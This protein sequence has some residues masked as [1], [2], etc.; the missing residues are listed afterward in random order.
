MGALLLS[1]GIIFVAELGDKTMVA[2]VTL[3]ATEDPWAVWLGSI[4]G[5]VAADA[6]AIAVGRVLGMRLPERGVSRFAVASFVVFG[7]LLLL[8]ASRG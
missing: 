7:S 2:T 1:F 8:D 5:M 6:L 3:A 4:V